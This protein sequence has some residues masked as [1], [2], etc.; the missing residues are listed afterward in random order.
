MGGTT[1][2]ETDSGFHQTFLLSWSISQHLQ[3]I[4]VFAGQKQTESSFGR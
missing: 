2:Q 1:N 4:D 3:V